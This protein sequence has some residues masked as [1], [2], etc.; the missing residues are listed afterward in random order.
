M[1]V[2]SALGRLLLLLLDRTS[3]C[4][5][6][7]E[8][9]LLWVYNKGMK[10][11]LIAVDAPGPAEFIAPV[12]PLLKKFA[13]IKIA[14]V[15]ESPARVLAEFKPERCDD[16]TAADKIYREFQP[17][18]L[19]LAMS[20]LVT[21]PYVASRFTDL[22]AEESRPIICFQDLWANHRWPMNFKMMPKWNTLLT[23]DELAKTLILQDNFPGRVHITG[24]P[25]FDK[26]RDENVSAER[27]K[28][29]KKFGVGP[30]DFIIVYC[31]AG[32]PGGWREDEITFQFLA[33]ALTEFQNENPE[34]RLIARPHPRDEEPG[35]YQRLAPHLNYLDT[36]SVAFSD[37]LLP[38]ADVVVGMYAT[39]LI[40]ACYLRIPGISILLP[41]AG[42]KRLAENLLLPDFPPNQMGATIGIYKEK[43]DDIN[44]ELR[45]IMNKDASLSAMKAAQGRFFAFD[46]KSATQ[47]VADVIRQEL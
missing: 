18:M 44:K 38:I 24:N 3:A 2:N 23:L 10:K 16:V 32:T 34:S 40:H 5:R 12:I 47:R 21:G 35:R 39:N 11:I 9:G 1:L 25:A 17:E 43:T 15:K 42:R 7:G 33:K 4:L 26:F 31:G 8:A 29:R 14:V 20:S 45:K 13:K 30:E 19:L 37:E 41:D 36:S 22:A 46:K 6:E 28:L 27:A